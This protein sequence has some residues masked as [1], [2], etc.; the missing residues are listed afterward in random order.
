MFELERILKWKV[1]NTLRFYISTS[2]V[3]TSEFHSYH[4]LNLFWQC[5]DS[6]IEKVNWTVSLERVLTKVFE[7]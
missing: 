7:A 5:F 1:H 6:F 3:T 4:Y 2:I